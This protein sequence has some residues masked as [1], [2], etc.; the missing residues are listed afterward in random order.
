[1]YDCGT[2]EEILKEEFIRELYGLE[3]GSFDPVFGSIE[4]PRQEG[5][6]RTAVI[7]AGGRGIPVYRRLQKEGIPFLAGIL[8][9]NDVDYHLAGRLA[10]RV[11]AEEPFQDI[12]DPV[13]E[14]AKEAFLRCRRVIYTDIPWGGCN[15]RLKELLEEVRSRE[16]IAC[17]HVPQR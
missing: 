17:V 12:S 1:M 8:Y 7:S 13:Y 2:P 10:S 11:I 9:R 3:K 4:L 14:E 15:R 5:E 6:P 16:E